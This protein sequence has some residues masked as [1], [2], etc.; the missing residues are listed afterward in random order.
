M[1]FQAE[2]QKYDPVTAEI[3]RSW[4]DLCEKGDRSSPEEYP[5]H[6]LITFDE[7]ADYMRRAVAAN[8]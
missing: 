7:L 8:K 4:V 5:D 6:C 2:A 3:L 1:S